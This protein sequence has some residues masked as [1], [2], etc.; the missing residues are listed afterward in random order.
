M[1]HVFWKLDKAVFLFVKDVEDNIWLIT[2]YGVSEDYSFASIEYCIINAIYCHI[3][4]F[5][6]YISFTQRF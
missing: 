5:K 3:P 6:H 4:T 1:S 2:I